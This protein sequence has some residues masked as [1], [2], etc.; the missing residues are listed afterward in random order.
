VKREIKFRMYDNS[1]KVMYTDKM[2]EEIKNLWCLPAA[3]GGVLESTNDRILMQFTGLKD[4]NGN[5]IYEGDIH[6][7]KIEVDGKIINSAIPIV[8]DNC[9]FWL[10]ESFNKDKTYLS[11]LCEYDTPINIIGNIHENPELLK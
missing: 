4:K 11:L 6:S 3:S 10:D 8:F 9:A 2:N 7:E 1:L 5:D